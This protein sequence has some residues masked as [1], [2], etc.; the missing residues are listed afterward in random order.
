ML[1]RGIGQTWRQIARGVGF[2][3]GIG[4]LLLSYLRPLRAL[5]YPNAHRRLLALPICQSLGDTKAF[6]D[7][8]FHHLSH[9]YYLRQGL[10]LRQRIDYAHG[11]FAFESQ[12][13]SED[14]YRAVYGGGGLELWRHED[15]GSE[16]IIRL[17]FAPKRYV[18]E[19]D[20]EIS[21]LVNSLP[22]HRISF[23]WINSTAG[24]AAVPFVGCS[25][26]LSR[27]QNTTRQDEDIASAFDRCFPHSAP[28]YF[29]FAAL[30]GVAQVVGSPGL[31]AVRGHE[32]ICFKDSP[33]AAHYRNSYDRLWRTLGGQDHGALGYFI[34]LPAHTKPLSELSRSHRRRSLKR[35]EIWSEVAGSAGNSLAPLKR[36]PGGR[37]LLPF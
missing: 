8:P 27:S 21:L 31:Y 15:S 28:S 32:Q 24:M 16:I 10:T 7:D 25:Q 30:Q 2:R 26:A 34:P 12:E 5:A 4:P 17:Q 13:W 9:R 6:R 1:I 3:Y 29:C 11:H 20:L 36:R 19:G 35:R 37:E 23:S 33:S 22:S 18:T 14:Y